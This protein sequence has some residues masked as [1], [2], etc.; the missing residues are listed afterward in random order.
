MEPWLAH[1]EKDLNVKY[2][3]PVLDSAKPVFLAW[4]ETGVHR[5]EKSQPA[6][7]DGDLREAL[8]CLKSREE[9][10]PEPLGET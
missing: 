8:M 1:S 10:F 6:E 2:A 4:M 3:G 9:S 5:Q 7:M